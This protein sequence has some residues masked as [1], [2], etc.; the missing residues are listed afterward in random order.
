MQDDLQTIYDQRFSGREDYWRK[1]WGVLISD[2]FYRFIPA[3]GAVLDLGCGYEEFINQVQ[4]SAR[5][6]M[7]LNPDS[8]RHLHP[9]VCL[10]QQACS[11]QWPCQMTPLTSSSR[12]ISS[13]ICPGNRAWRRP[14]TRLVVVSGLAGV[15]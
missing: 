15:L 10:F 9:D 1:V 8:Q 11:M 13:N 2:W 6:R 12:A 5:Y 4:A 7:D 14:S 3:E